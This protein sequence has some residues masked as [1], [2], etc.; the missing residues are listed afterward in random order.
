MP[1][2]YI[3]TASKDHIETG[4]AKKFIQQKHPNRIEKLKKGDFVVMYASKESYGKAKSYQKF[5]AIA[6]CLDDKY[7][8][9]E[10]AKDK[11]S[12]K[13]D[14]K[15]S[16]TPMSK[17]ANDLYFFRKK[18]KFI[19]FREVEIRPLIESLS[20]IKNKKSWGMIFMNGFKQIP[21]EDFTLITSS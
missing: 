17:G 19:K 9:L 3:I 2:Y 7:E 8:K 12:C 13:H 6:E 14:N 15:L 20:F 11:N 10:K 5:I 4:V 18:V 16:H 21:E 1:N